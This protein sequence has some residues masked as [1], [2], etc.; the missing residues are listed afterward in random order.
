MALTE[1]HRRERNAE[2]QARYRVRGK[3]AK[4]LGLASWQVLER[5]PMEDILRAPPG[6]YAAWAVAIIKAHY[7]GRLFPTTSEPKP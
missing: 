4:E 3:R 6:M 1:D 7:E 5:E 2:A